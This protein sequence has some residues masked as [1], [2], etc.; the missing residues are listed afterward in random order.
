MVMPEAHRHLSDTDAGIGV[1]GAT[2]AAHD[3]NSADPL[4]GSGGGE[5][6]RHITC[7]TDDQ[8]TIND[9][10]SANGEPIY[11]D[12]GLQLTHRRDPHAFRS[13]GGGPGR[14]GMNA[15]ANDARAAMASDHRQRRMLT[16]V[17]LGTAALFAVV[18][19]GTAVAVSTMGHERRVAA[20]AE[21]TA[22]APFEEGR[23]LQFKQVA[24]PPTLPGD[25]QQQQPSAASTG[26]SRHYAEEV[27]Q[28]LRLE[29]DSW[30]ERHKRDYGSH[31]ERER[32]FGIWLD[33]H[34]E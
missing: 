1:G 10:S 8:Q 5:T 33:N 4:D 23:A 6:T 18:V 15:R 24:R 26:K 34:H 12:S 30:V 22:S 7:N 16:Y 20:S 31:E 11:T 28:E 19:L 29:F 3:D 17:R 13:S 25:V 32:R 9:E 14:V 21:A 2:A 27:V